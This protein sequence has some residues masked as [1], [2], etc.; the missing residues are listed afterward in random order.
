MLDI[1]T[2]TKVAALCRK[3]TVKVNGFRNTNSC[4]DGCEVRQKQCGVKAGSVPRSI[5]LCEIIM[6]V[7]GF[8]EHSNLGH[9]KS[10]L[11]MHME[12]KHYYSVDNKENSRENLF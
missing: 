9:F 5:K 3:G 1:G 4:L 10:T 6:Y 7:F 12:T 2:S 11:N 8:L